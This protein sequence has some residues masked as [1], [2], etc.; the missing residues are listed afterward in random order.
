[1]RFEKSN[2]PVEYLEFERNGWGAFIGGYNGTFGAVT[3][4]TV[5]ATLDAAE[6]G[7]GAR[8][9]DICCGPGMLSEA[10][11]DIRGLG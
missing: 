9:L 8:V 7:G 4:Q 6:V 3:R 11:A 5:K 1:M 2:A 10:G